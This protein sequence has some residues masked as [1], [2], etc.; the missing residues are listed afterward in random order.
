[1]TS[2]QPPG[3]RNDGAGVSDEDAGTPW[4]HERCDQE[5]A[6]AATDTVVPNVQGAIVNETPDVTAFLGYW[7]IMHME[8][9]AQKYVDLVVPGF[10]EF[11]YEDDLLMGTFQFGTVSG[12]LDCR[13]R[14]VGGV[15]FIDWSWQGQ[16]DTDP[17][18]GRGWAQLVDGRL[19]GWI[20][21]HAGDDSAFRATKKPRPAEGLTPAGK[22]RTDTIERRYH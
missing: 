2:C 7:K 6:D 3:N 4:M 14:D 11:T 19:V 20:F 9:W 1:M 12:G 16:N 17:G 8:T 15:T 22:G 13:L 21:I 10:V 5:R 18:N